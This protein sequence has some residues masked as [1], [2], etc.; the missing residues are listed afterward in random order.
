[1]SDAWSR[2]RFLGS[3]A[4]LPFAVG[5]A[6]RAS[7]A[8]AP[9]A[10]RCAILDAR[11]DPVPARELQRFYVCDLLS[12]PIPIEPQVTAGSVVFAPPSPPFRIGVPL[13]V[14]GFGRP[15]VY[16]DNRGEGHTPRSVSR[17]APL[18]LN[19]ELAADRL[20]TVRRLQ[21]ECRE[22]G[23]AVSSGV[24]A[25]VADA[26]RLL[27]AAE[28][29]ADDPPAAARPAMESLRESLWAGEMIVVERARQRIAQRGP[30]PGFLF[31]CNAFG[32]NDYGRPF[33]ERFEAVFDYAT[34][35]FYHS[36]VEPV[37]GQRDYSRVDSLLSWLGSTRIICKGHPLIFPLGTVMPPWLRNRPFDETRRGCLDYVS[38][39]VSRYRD[40]IHV[41]DVL[42]E[43]HVQPEVGTGYTGFTCEKNVELTRQALNAAREADPTCYRIVNSTGTWGDYYLGRQPAVWQ[44]SVY[45][46]LR[47]LEEARCD[48]EAIGLQYYHSG[49]DML[50]FERDLDRFEAFGKPIQISEVGF[51][52][53]SGDVPDAE[54]WGGGKGG[55]RMAW[56][57]ESF[58]EET[59]ADWLEQVYTIAFSKPSVVA[60]TWWDLSDPAFI[61][62]GG[63]VRE[64]MTPKKS[65][66]RLAAL[67]RQWRGMEPP[68]APGEEG[69]G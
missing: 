14:P 54:W 39:S 58:S 33:A 67:R 43:L 63:L 68:P 69:P 8:A 34:L 13:T 1:M 35:P 56:H 53:S 48:Y 17:H 47:Q 37:R 19:Y 31:G 22:A 61:P 28:A 36:G 16:A 57:G 65:Y 46:Y 66:E 52:S 5:P 41:W 3:A 55:S 11:G 59:Q 18:F 25:R 49:R 64:D 23:F 4:A 12:R 2:R 44:Q 51:P 42:N 30:R 29:L 6:A 20:A 40:R 62:H 60:L 9:A 45:D 27:E 10:A 32:Y 50:E 7:L 38:A 21:G 26:E 24:V 15:F